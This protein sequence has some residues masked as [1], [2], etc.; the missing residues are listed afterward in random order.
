MTPIN[1]ALNSV[2]LGQM[3]QK[4]A[5]KMAQAKYDALTAK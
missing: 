1:E 5:L 2:L 3:T 4:E